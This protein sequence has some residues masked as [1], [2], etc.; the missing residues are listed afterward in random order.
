MHARRGRPPALPIDPR[1][2]NRLRQLRLRAGLKQEDL[3]E[4]AGIS[5][6]Q[7]SKMENGRAPLTLEQARR[8]AQ[9][10]GCSPTDLLPEQGGFTVP[11]TLRAAMGGG[12]GALPEPHRRVT[13]LPAIA[14]VEDCFAVE[15]AD[16]HADRLYPKGADVVVRPVAAAL[17]QLGQKIAVRRRA[18]VLVGVLGE[19][20][21]DLV[22]ILRSSVA[23]M[24][25]ALPVQLAPGRGV[26]E[27]T[28]RYVDPSARVDYAPRAGD[29]AEILGTI[30]MA[31]V[32]E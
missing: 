26:A 12:A 32:P 3:A 2:A 29:P 27:R 24:P 23:G 30:V 5:Q 17:P 9:I 11:V 18:D 19:T 4:R 13:A 1:R 25:A 6:Q 15:I 14:D 22:L 31:I 16:E 20:H 7:I 21:G 8:V 28:F 10:L